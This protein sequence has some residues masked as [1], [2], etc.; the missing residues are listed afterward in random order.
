MAIGGHHW[1]LHLLDPTAGGQV[2]QQQH[3]ITVEIRG[4]RQ[5][6]TLGQRL[7]APQALGILRIEQAVLPLPGDIAGALANHAE[8]LAEMADALAEQF[9]LLGQLGLLA[10][11][12]GF[13]TLGLDLLGLQGRPRGGEQLR[14]LATLG[15]KCLLAALHGRDFGGTFAANALQQLIRAE[16]RGST[17]QRGQQRQGQNGDNTTA[18]CLAS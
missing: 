6:A 13:Q 10:I 15:D 5:G 16:R 17:G 14:P 11:E 1:H 18:H 9:F 3:P 4:G 7:E 8:Q 2:F 12:F